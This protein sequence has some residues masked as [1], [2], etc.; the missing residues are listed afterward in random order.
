V[1]DSDP[2]SSGSFPAR[3]GSAWAT[4]EQPI[5][6]HWQ[7]V[8]ETRDP[9]QVSWFQPQPLTSLALIDELGIEPDAS[10]IDVGGGASGLTRRLLERGFTDLTVLDVAP[11]A[12]EVARNE[13]GPAAA[14]VRW[15][16][17][18]VLR[19]APERSYRLWHDRAVFHFLIDSADR[20]RYVEVMDS[21]IAPGGFAIVGTFAQDGPDR[22]SGLPVARY[23]ADA[24][25][26]AFATLGSVVAHR[27]ELHTTPAGTVQ[28]F[29]WVAVGR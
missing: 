9:N 14:G 27:R 4:H 1:V 21:A 12:L 28:P 16:A 22:C 23:D 7:Q 24:L 2:A 20:E 10:V 25:A 3:I 8:Y 13:L 29:T 15:L 26:A 6:T 18:D 17:Q 19:F 5:S 11:R